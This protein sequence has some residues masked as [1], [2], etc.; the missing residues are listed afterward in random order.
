MPMRHADRR[1]TEVCR[2][3]EKYPCDTNE[4]EES[5]ASGV[6]NPTKRTIVVR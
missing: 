5:T 4:D 6:D 1:G 2:V 3:R